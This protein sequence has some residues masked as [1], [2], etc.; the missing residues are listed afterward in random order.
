MITSTLQQ[1][2]TCATGINKSPQPEQ[3]LCMTCEP[4]KSQGRKAHLPKKQLRSYHP[5]KIKTI[6]PPT[7]LPQNCLID[8]RQRSNASAHID[9]LPPTRNSRFEFPDTIDLIEAKEGHSLPINQP[10]YERLRD[11]VCQR[12]ELLSRLDIFRVPHLPILGLETQIEKV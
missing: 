8:A 12:I 4:Q 9:T 11:I 7:S 10:G 3:K 5:K 1:G 6:L 2:I